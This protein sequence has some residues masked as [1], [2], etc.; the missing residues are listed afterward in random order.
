MIQNTIVA[1]HFIDSVALHASP[2]RSKMCLWL[3]LFQWNS[4]RNNQG[5]TPIEK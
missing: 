5:K 4:K 3:A 2:K 1:N